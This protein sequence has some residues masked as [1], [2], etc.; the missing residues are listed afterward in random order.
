MLW[1]RVLQ[2]SVSDVE[3]CRDGGVGAVQN[4]SVYMAV[5]SCPRC[6][7]TECVQVKCEYGGVYVVCTGT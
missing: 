2:V 5:P 3:A 7:N 1:I 4:I 6:I